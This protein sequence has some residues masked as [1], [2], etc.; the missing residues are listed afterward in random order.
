MDKVVNAPSRIA[1]DVNYY[2]IEL[3][4]AVQ[5]GWKPPDFVPFELYQD[6]RKHKDRYEPELVGFVGFGCTFGGKWFGGYARDKEGNNYAARAVGALT[7]QARLIQGVD[8]RCGSYADL[9]IPEH[10]LVYCDPPYLGT[11]GYKSK[12][13]HKDFWDWVRGFD[14]RDVAVLVS[15]YAAPDGFFYLFQKTQRVD[16]NKA[17]ARNKRE[18]VFVSGKTLDMILGE[19]DI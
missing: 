9:E 5:N 6:I 15:E 12:I 10:S 16:V 1:N 13:D 3:F 18:K 11:T 7:K 4:R 8:I 17:T 2:L 14:C 19:T